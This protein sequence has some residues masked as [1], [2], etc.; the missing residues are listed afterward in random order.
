MSKLITYLK[1]SE[2]MFIRN[3]DKILSSINLK[4]SDC[5][6]EINTFFS[7]NKINYNKFFNFIHEMKTIIYSNIYFRYRDKVI[8]EL[9][10]LMNSDDILENKV[11]FFENEILCYKKE[12]FYYPENVKDNIILVIKMY[13]KIIK[14]LKKYSN[15]K[16]NINILEFDNSEEKII[17]FDVGL[18]NYHNI[19]Y[20][21]K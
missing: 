9:N 6:N 15:S 8:I 4:N 2:I 5:E 17:K 14:I 10:S 12:F 7:N 3:T 11:L 19:C 18:S 20:I 16:T 21:T 1:G 13:E